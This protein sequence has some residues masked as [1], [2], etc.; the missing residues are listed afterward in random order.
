MSE[1]TLTYR[2]RLLAASLAAPLQVLSPVEARVAEIAS[3]LRF[4]DYLGL[5]IVETGGTLEKGRALDAATM[6]RAVDLMLTAAARMDEGLRQI[7][8]EVER[9]AEPKG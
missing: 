9:T 4:S 5:A 1:N 7:R 3:R 8:G 2:R 6:K